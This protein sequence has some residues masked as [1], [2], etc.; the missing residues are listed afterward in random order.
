MGITLVKTNYLSISFGRGRIH[1]L[2]VLKAI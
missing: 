2:Q 1:D